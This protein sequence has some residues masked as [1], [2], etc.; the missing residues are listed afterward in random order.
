MATFDLSDRLA[1]WV[2][3]RVPPAFKQ[4]GID[5][6]ESALVLFALGLESQLRDKIV[7]SEDALLLRAQQFVETGPM[8]YQDMYGDNVLTFN[9]AVHLLVEL[10]TRLN[11]FPW[12]PSV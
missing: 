5:V 8:L 4:R 12:G 3:E 1:A 9:R 7:A 10:N 6:T 2:G 11:T